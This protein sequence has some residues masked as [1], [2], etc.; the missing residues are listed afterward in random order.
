MATPKVSRVTHGK[1][2]PPE[3][4]SAILELSSDD[5]GDDYSVE[6]PERQTE[7]QIVDDTCGHSIVDQTLPNFMS[8]KIHS[9]DAQMPGF[10]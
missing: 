4:E 9:A 6:S 8:H 1:K 10:S 7:V 2:A 5:G 3:A